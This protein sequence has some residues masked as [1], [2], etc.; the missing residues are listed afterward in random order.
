MSRQTGY[1]LLLLAVLAGS[2]FA[3][4]DKELPGRTA[5]SRVS[6]T[7]STDGTKSRKRNRDANPM[8]LTPSRKAA[9]L[10]FARQHHPEL[11]SLLKGLE[12]RN[13]R[14]F[15]R[16]MTQL[17][18]TSERLAHSKERFSSERFE[19][20]L[21]AW[22]DDSRLRLLAARSALSKKKDAKLERELDEV[23]AHRVEIRIQLMRLEKRRMEQR[24]AKL[25]MTIDSIDAERDK[26][27]AQ[28]LNRINRGLGIKPRKNRSTKRKSAKRKSKKST[29]SS[30]NKKK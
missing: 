6:T 17:Y 3:W 30:S 15:R 9:A 29:D 7:S 5:K 2:A 1:S 4:A 28:L 23:L 25:S 26:A 19:L 20:E 18:K 22:K 27:K 16:A 8:A 24:A 12:K 11:A 10:E 13:S 21:A 14:A